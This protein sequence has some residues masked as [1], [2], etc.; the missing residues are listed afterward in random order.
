MPGQ[1]P[2]C[3]ELV[4]RIII[5]FIQVFRQQ[6]YSFLRCVFG[7][8]SFQ[9]LLLSVCSS[10]RK[11]LRWQGSLLRCSQFPKRK[12][13]AT[14]Q[15]ML[16]GF[17][18]IGLPQR[19]WMSFSFNEVNPRS[20]TLNKHTHTHTHTKL[21]KLCW[22]VVPCLPCAVISTMLFTPSSTNC[23]GR[24]AQSTHVQSRRVPFGGN[25]AKL[26]TIG[27]NLSRVETTH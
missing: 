22:Q 1:T 12:N 4:G 21:G 5:K 23:W 17:V 10:F 6:M 26:T 20:G 18:K 8:P 14:N 25:Q 27:I 15:T 24:C 11:Y 7:L 9:G 16:Q 19:S 13:E 2:F 3:L